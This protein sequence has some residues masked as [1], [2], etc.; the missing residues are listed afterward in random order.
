[1]LFKKTSLFGQAASCEIPLDWTDVSTLRT[2][3]SHQEVYVD[4][5]EVPGLQDSSVI[6]EILEREKI[7]DDQTAGTF[8]FTDLAKA[9]EAVSFSIDAPR[10]CVLPSVSFLGTSASRVYIEGVQVKGKGSDSCSAKP[11]AVFMTVLRAK[12]YDTD[13]L[14][15]THG[16]VDEFGSDYIRQVHKKISESLVFIDPT[17]FG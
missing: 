12:D 16:A 14:V 13:I 8:F 11:V 10:S 7:D 15:T 3:P 2:V 5:S 1:M 9:D 6:I 4:S 17:L